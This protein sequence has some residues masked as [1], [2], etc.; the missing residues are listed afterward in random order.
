MRQHHSHDPMGLGYYTCLCV[1]SGNHHI[2]VL[3]DLDTIDNILV[4]YWHARIL[5]T[6]SLQKSDQSGEFLIPVCRL[7]KGIL[8]CQYVTKIL[9]IVSKSHS[10][11]MWWL[12]LLYKKL[13]VG[14]SIYLSQCSAHVCCRV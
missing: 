3:C 7:F 6:F 5:S 9:S 1:I 4:T 10:T 11:V 14:Y 8:A 13:N 12:P 2:T